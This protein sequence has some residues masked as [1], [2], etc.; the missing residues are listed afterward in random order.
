[1][2]SSKVNAVDELKQ[3]SVDWDKAM[4]ENDVMRIG[5]F[6]ADDWVMVATEGGIT[7]K[8]AF[9]EYIKPGSL[10]HDKMDFENIKVEIYGDT[11]VIVA[12]GT[13][14][15][16]YKENPFSYYEWSTSIYRRN[17]SSWLCVLTMLTPAN[18]TKI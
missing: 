15:G 2:E 16:T 17:G 1:M 11:A 9:L 10:L 6:M 5:S 18:T 8:A 4:L 7:S 13:S 3:F 12:R 14:A